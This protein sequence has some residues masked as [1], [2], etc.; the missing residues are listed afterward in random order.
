MGSID[1]EPNLK[2][3]EREGNALDQMCGSVAV[4]RQKRGTPDAYNYRDN[5]IYSR[6]LPKGTAQE[7]HECSDD[8]E[9]IQ[10]AALDECEYD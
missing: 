7:G 8:T 4:E 9:S 10:S 3:Y 2:H 6:I 1:M 5:R